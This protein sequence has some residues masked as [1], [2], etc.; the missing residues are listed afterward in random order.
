MG[1]NPPLSS[2]ALESPIPNAEPA[3]APL[4]LRF[5]SKGKMA[6]PPFNSPNAHFPSPVTPWY[7]TFIKALLV[8][9]LHQLPCLHELTPWKLLHLRVP[10]NSSQIPHESSAVDLSQSFQLL[11]FQNWKPR[12]AKPLT[13]HF[14]VTSNTLAKSLQARLFF[15]GFL[16]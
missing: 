15:H 3:R 8:Q 13:I 9:R 1:K 10:S 11:I 2:E 4:C 12:L 14:Y 7:K 16:F 6:L 5:F